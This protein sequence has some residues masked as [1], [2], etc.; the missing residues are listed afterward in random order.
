MMAFLFA[1]G[2]A[3]LTQFR[4]RS[5]KFFKQYGYPQTQP[6]SVEYYC[7]LFFLQYVGWN[8]CINHLFHCPSDCHPMENRFPTGFSAEE[9][10]HSE[11][12][13]TMSNY[14]KTVGFDIQT[15]NQKTASLEE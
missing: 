9:I 8:G 4:L 6:S 15:L 11:I 7:R 2:N 5:G 10:P 1:R 3:F 14:K 12:D 13:S